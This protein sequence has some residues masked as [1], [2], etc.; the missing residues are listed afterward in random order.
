[1]GTN[2]QENTPAIPWRVRIALVAGGLPALLFVVACLVY[3]APPSAAQSR[4]QPRA[5]SVL[6]PY[7]WQDW[8]LFAPT[9]GSADD[10]VYLKTRLRHPD[11]AIVETGEVE[12]ET[13]V[14][15]TPRRFPLNPTK[16][17]GIFLSLD[18]SAH[19]YAAAMQKI[20]ELPADARA[21]AQHQLDVSFKNTFLQLQRFM[22]ARAAAL[23][24]GREVLAVRVTFGERSI[25]PYSQ[26]YVSPPSVAR[27]NL[28]YG[29]GAGSRRLSWSR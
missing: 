26:R 18:G 28:V 14:D 8:Q 27:L 13:A 29:C 21:Q 24:P 10:E 6:E 2:G 4:L 25:V 15:R 5:A 16:L 9:P 23:Y 20:D 11:G 17:P 12:V 7:F 1:M 19:R 3:N 22:S